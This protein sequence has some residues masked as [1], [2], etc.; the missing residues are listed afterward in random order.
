M[1]SLNTTNDQTLSATATP[2]TLATLSG[3]G[4]FELVCDLSALDDGDVVRISIETKHDAGDSD[5]EQAVG[6]YAHSGNGK[7]SS[8]P[9]SAVSQWVAK[10]ESLAGTGDVIPWYVLE[11]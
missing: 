5:Q 8:G 1:V 11:Y 6:Y 9:I 10:I 7:V 2:Y 3:P 4:T